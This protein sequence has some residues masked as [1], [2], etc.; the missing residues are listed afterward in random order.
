VRRWGGT[1]VT[2]FPFSKLAGYLR[3]RGGDLG[4]RAR[5]YLQTRPP[6]EEE[7][8]ARSGPAR[9]PRQ[10]RQ[11]GS[12]AA[13]TRPNLELAFGTRHRHRLASAGRHSHVTQRLGGDLGG[14]K[15][16]TNNWKPAFCHSCFPSFRLPFLF[17]YLPTFIDLYLWHFYIYI[18]IWYI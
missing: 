5:A 6:L 8:P 3:E 13:S 9:Q 12:Q 17:L 1:F 14:T 18:Y 16:G 7:D 2:K 10:P 4:E 15:W 11:S